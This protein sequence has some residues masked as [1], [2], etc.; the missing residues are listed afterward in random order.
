MQFWILHVAEDP[1]WIIEL[2]IVQIGHG[3]ESLGIAV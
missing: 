1:T 2:A 3:G